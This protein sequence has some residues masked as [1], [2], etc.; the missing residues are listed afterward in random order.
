VLVVLSAPA[1]AG[2]CTRRRWWCCSGT[3]ARADPRIR[4]CRG[5]RTIQGRP[6]AGP[7]WMSRPVRRTIP[8]RA[9]QTARGTRARRPRLPGVFLSVKTITSTGPRSLLL[10]AAG[11]CCRGP[12][13]RGR[14]RAPECA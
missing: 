9:H 5:F 4:A 7:G 14:G 1:T 12:S 11:G 10:R 6:V 2:S 13:R 8:R 3:S